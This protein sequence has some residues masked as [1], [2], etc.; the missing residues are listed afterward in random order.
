MAERPVLE[1]WYEFA[2]TYSYLAAMR[3]ETLAAAAGVDIRWRP[4]LLGPIFAAQGWAT[5]PFNLYPAKGRYMWR[6]MARETERLGLPLVIPDP[7]PQNA[8]LAARV[9][10]VGANHP[11]CPTFTK[12][13]YRAE[14]GEGRNIAEPEVIRGVLV[15]MGLDAEKILTAALTD[16]NKAGLKASTEEALARGVFGAPAFFAPD[17]EMFWG[18]DRLDQALAWTASA[19][20]S[21]SAEMRGEPIAGPTE[22]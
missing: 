20:E 15:H 19:R 14:F 8:L 11:W 17:G 22:G 1:F 16:D 10:L 5:S 3:I 9:A 6:D 13:V 21:A 7:F 18:N 4:F 2:S 12:A